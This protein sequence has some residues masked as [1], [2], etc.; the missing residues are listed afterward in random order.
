MVPHRVCERSYGIVK[1]E[2]IFVLVL[3]EG[4]H[5]GVQD[6]CQIGHQLC[7]GLLLQSGKGTGWDRFQ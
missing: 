6:E 2:Q 5:Q 4:K 3:A 1:N 7:A